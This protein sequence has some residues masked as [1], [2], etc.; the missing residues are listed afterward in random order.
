M[1]R[2]S[3]I[4]KLTSHLLLLVVI[5]ATSAVSPATA[6]DFNNSGSDEFCGTL[7]ARQRNIHD[8]IATVQD[9]VRQSWQRQNERLRVMD[10]EQ[11][12]SQQDLWRIIDAQRNRNLELVRDRAK[13]PA[14]QQAVRDYGIAQKQANGSRRS[15]IASANV[16]FIAALKRYIGNR[17]ATQAGQVEAL[18]I[19]LDDDL[20]AASVQCATGLASQDVAA[21]FSKSIAIS[22]QTYLQQRKADSAILG[23]VQDLSATRRQ[24]AAAADQTYMVTMSSARHTLQAAFK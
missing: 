18:R 9:E 20:R 19:N 7:E 23:Q 15:S 16:S 11:Q 5:V 10:S 2:N 13:T 1:R 24:A 3:K 4:L 17:Q 8:Q 22:R 12:S 14:Q 21:R 6:L